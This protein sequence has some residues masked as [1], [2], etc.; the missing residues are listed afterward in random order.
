[1]GMRRGVVLVG[2]LALALSEAH[3]RAGWW[4][5]E[6]P[7]ASVEGPWDTRWTLE[8][9]DRLRGDAWAS[10]PSENIAAIT[11]YAPSPLSYAFTTRSL[12]SIG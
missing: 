3:A 7:P 4:P 9:S 10:T 11:G 2:A 1:M 6:R 5:P 12:S 8:A